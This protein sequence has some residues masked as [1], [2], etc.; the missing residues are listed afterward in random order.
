VLW[1][2]LTWQRAMAHGARFQCA[3]FATFAT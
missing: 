3:R 1:A 2:L